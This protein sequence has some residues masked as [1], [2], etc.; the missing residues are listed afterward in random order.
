MYLQN[1][2]WKGGFLMRKIMK[3]SVATLVLVFILG[4]GLFS[5]TIA[6]AD[7][8][9]VT[10]NGTTVV[11]DGQGPTIVD[12][13]TLVPVRGVFE[14]LGFEV[15][16]DQGRQVATLTSDDYIVEIFVGRLFFR[17][18]E[19]GA[20][21]ESD[22]QTWQLDVPAQIINGRT[23]LPIRAVLE[24]VG[25][26]V[27]WHADARTVIVTSEPIDPEDLEFYNP[28]AHWYNWHDIP[29]S[30]WQSTFT[31]VNEGNALGVDWFRAVEVGV[32][33]SF[34]Y[35]HVPRESSPGTFIAP[36]QLFMSQPSTSVAE[37]REMFADADFE[38]V[39]DDYFEQWIILAYT[40]E[41]AFRFMLAD[42]NDTNITSI[43]ISRNYN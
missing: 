26:Y 27:G 29:F 11:F 4:L 40:S 22:G 31:L 5:P 18:Y 30:A 33:F 13:R 2:L 21:L 16:W 9:G 6:Y 7:E 35:G 23:L 32:M 24:A 1:C 42:E 41:H 3:L 25:Y 34:D 38:M 37:L 19:V 43:W 8:I 36:I 15:N 28:I 14:Q 39:F 10:I 20:P 17:L 12:G